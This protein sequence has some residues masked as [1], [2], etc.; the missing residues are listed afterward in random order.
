[1]PIYEYQCTKCG[2]N[3]EYL[4]LSEGEPEPRC[5]SCCGT[6]VKRL[7]SAGSIRAQGI[8]TGGGGF[9]GSGCRPSGG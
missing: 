9:K 6:D 4:K 3:F 5:P 1:M 8:P 7:I 2:C